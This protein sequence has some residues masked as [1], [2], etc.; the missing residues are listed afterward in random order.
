MPE[1]SPDL[2][3]AQLVTDRPARARVFERLGIDY[4]CGGDHSLAEACTKNDLDTSTV[5]QMLDVVAESAPA[6][7]TRNW[8]DVPLT[9]L[10]D[11]IK[12]AHHKYLR[13]ELPRLERLIGKTNRAHGDQVSWLAPV[14]SLFLSLREDLMD[15]M[16]SEEEYV[17]PAIRTL[18]EGRVLPDGSSLD[19]S[20]L[21][22]MEDEHD[23]AGS[24]LEQLRSLTNEYTPPEWACPTFRAAIDGLRELE[25]D[26]HQHVHKEN[27]IL[28]PRARS[29]A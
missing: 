11:H 24:A 15:H 25:S 16:Q 5:V 13:R 21:E 26:M 8:S 18:A 29:L 2:S 3:V 9:D 1:I 12:E 10:I 22:Q 4:C 7:P 19:A 27:N 17:F 23:E 14:Q 28:F 20:A 6:E